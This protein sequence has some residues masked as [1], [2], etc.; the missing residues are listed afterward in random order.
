[1]KRVKESQEILRNLGL[2]PAQRNEMA[3]L[4]LLAL[5]GIGRKT[6]WSNASRR[7]LTVTK[8]IMEFVGREYR[9]EYAPNTRETFRRQVLHQFVQAGLVDYNPDKPDLPTNSPRAHYA[10]SEDA[11]LLI[12]LFGTSEW[13][14]AATAYL[15]RKRALIEVYR[16]QRVHHNVP[17]VLADGTRLELSPGEHNVLQAAV[18]TEFGPRFAPGAQLLYVGDTARKD[19]YVDEGGLSQLEIPISEH[20]KLADV[21]LY[22]SARNWLFLVEAVTSHGPM[23]PKRVL[24]LKELMRN[25]R[26]GLVFV[27]AFPDFTEFRKHIRAPKTMTLQVNRR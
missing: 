22:D 24:E 12:R 26:A 4:T 25:C 7:S 9:K 15:A 2:P 10:I 19:L 11:L 20:W 27:S 6:P 1:M 17:V 21:V 23:T 3:A 18:I 8:G 14:S 5:C 13:Q 16:G